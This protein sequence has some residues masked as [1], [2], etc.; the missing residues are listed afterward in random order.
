MFLLHYISV[1]CEVD[2]FVNG[3]I[4]VSMILMVIFGFTGS[5]WFRGVPVQITH[6]RMPE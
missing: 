3:V 2:T 5:L 4:L 1:F 6:F